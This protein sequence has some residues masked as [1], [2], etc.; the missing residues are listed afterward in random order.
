MSAVRDSWGCTWADYHGREVDEIAADRIR[1][2]SFVE[3]REA[4]ADWSLA[5]AVGR[6]RLGFRAWL[7]DRIETEVT[8]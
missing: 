1:D 8:A 5:R 6:T 3:K 4:W 7:F 2:M